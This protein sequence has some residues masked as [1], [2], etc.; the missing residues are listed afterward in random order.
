MGQSMC[1]VVGWEEMV[2]LTAYVVCMRDIANPKEG[3]LLSL[4][5]QKSSSGAASSLIWE[6]PAVRAVVDYHWSHWARRFL[7]AVFCIFLI[8]TVAFGLYICLYIVLLP[9]VGRNGLTLSCCRNLERTVRHWRAMTR[10]PTSTILL[11]P[12]EIMA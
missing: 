11:R 8:W 4:L 3:D 2:K 12:L 1:C 9:R 10:A 7:L 6:F 5:L